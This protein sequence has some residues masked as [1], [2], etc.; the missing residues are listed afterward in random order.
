[1]GQHQS[2]VPA[3]ND[4]FA[5]VY[6]LKWQIAVDFGTSFSGFAFA[7]HEFVAAL[8][9]TPGVID[10]AAVPRL[11]LAHYIKYN[12][13]WPGGRVPY[14]KT[15]TALLYD[16]SG[17]VFA[18]GNEAWEHY[19]G[20]DPTRQ[21]QYIY[22]DRFKLLLDTKLAHHD[23]A[24]ERLKALG[25]DAVDVIAD[26]LRAL[27]EFLDKFIKHADSAAELNPYHV[28][29]CL[30]IPAM[31]SDAA[32]QK[33]SYAILKAGLISSPN[34][35]RVVFCSEPMAGLLS[36]A[37]SSDSRIRVQ[38]NDP[39]L[40]VDMGGGTVDLTAMRMGGN[41]FDELVPGL[42][43]SCG[44]TMLDDQFLA[45]FRRAVG[46]TIYDQVVAEHP[47]V[48]LQILRDWEVCKTSFMGEKRYYGRVP[49]PHRMVSPH[50]AV[51]VLSHEVDVD[52]GEVC[53][54]TALMESLYKPIVDQIV[55]LVTT[56][57]DRLKAKGIAVAHVLCVGGF[58]QSK[59][60]ISALRDRLPI[61]P[62]KIVASV[63]GPAAIL[64]GAPIFGC[65]PELIH[66]QVARL[67]YGIQ[68]RMLYQP[69]VHGPRDRL[70]DRLSMSDDGIT[71]VNNGFDAIIHKGDALL[72][73][74]V[75]TKSYLPSDC[76][77]T[78]ALFKVVVSHL[79]D[80]VYTDTV[81]CNE[82]GKVTIR[83]TPATHFLAKDSLRATVRVQHTGLV[84][85]V[86][87]ERTGAVVDMTVDFY[88]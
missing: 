62:A 86:A 71:R 34:S 24:M 6:P 32:K 17:T 65:R 13:S 74:Q 73:G 52:E 35:E 27:V 54:T 19:L 64:L 59:Y 58:S 41:G 66:T 47:K 53:M 5:P 33:M 4:L 38:R 10:L 57:L 46:P 18:W 83:V 15:R 68:T 76:T 50:D 51:D 40:M 25:K 72:P 31:W 75:I 23:P 3:P 39:I 1:M 88:D 82:V 20:M 30:T 69:S 43:A 81:G 79:E 2:Q 67:T 36:E 70:A 37:I 85:E 78:R 12:T 42:G 26:Y 7:I 28:R 29:W 21:A 11:H 61:D 9:N 87:N 60:L 48:R 80:P 14:P 55:G 63:H 22:I 49:I 45:M 8:N 44:S 16:A 84:L 56:M 77:Q